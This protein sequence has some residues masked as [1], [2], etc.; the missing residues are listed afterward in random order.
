MYFSPFTKDAW[1]GGMWQQPLVTLH[2]LHT[3]DSFSTQTPSAVDREEKSEVVPDLTFGRR[4]NK[5]DPE[6]IAVCVCVCAWGEG[7]YEV[8]EH[9]HQ[10]GFLFAPVVRLLICDAGGCRKGIPS[11]FILCL[12]RCFLSSAE[13][14]CF[15]TGCRKTLCSFVH[16]W[17]SRLKLIVCL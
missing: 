11:I 5:Q 16:S 4:E 14:G 17:R 1:S 3:P 12:R 6:C 9:R 13:V 15:T 10:Y 7:S 8:I 2:Y